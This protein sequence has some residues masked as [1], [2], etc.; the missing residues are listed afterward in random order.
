MGWFKMFHQHRDRPD[1]ILAHPKT[2]DATAMVDFPESFGF[3][4][5]V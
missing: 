5:L 1:I 3:V 4:Y 2:K